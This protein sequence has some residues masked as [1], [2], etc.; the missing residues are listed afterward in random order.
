M[1]E[2]RIRE[3]RF[4][5]GWLLFDLF[6]IWVSCDDSM[7]DYIEYKS[8]MSEYT[9]CEKEIIDKILR[10]GTSNLYFEYEV[11]GQR[12]EGCVLGGILDGGEGDMINIAFDKDMKYCR[13]NIVVTWANVFAIIFTFF[14]INELGKKVKKGSR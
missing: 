2:E 3:I 11:N 13:P 14:T 7:H 9:V 5:A 12:R 10:V 6:L 1:D 8:H 4:I